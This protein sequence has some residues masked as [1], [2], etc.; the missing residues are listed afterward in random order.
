LLLAWPLNNYWH[1]N[2][3]LT[4]PGRISLRYGLLTHGPF[5]ATEAQRQAAAFAQPVLVHP[6]FGG[7]PGEGTI[8]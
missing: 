8:S 5:D 7:G 4:Q 1:T 6:A 3:P 2:F